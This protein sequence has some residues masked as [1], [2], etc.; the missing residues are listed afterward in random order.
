MLVTYRVLSQFRYACKRGVDWVVREPV[1]WAQALAGI[2][3]CLRKRHPL[4]WADYQ[5]W[6][7]L[8]EISY[9]PVRSSS[10]TPEPEINPT[11]KA[12]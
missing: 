9:P 5:R 12:T 10:V 4:T 8:P 2:S 7:R 1:W 6:L 3:R 11:T